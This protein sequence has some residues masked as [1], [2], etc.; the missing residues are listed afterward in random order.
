MK[1]VRRIKNSLWE[2]RQRMGFSQERASR[3]LGFKKT[4]VLSRYENGM[5]IPGLVN[6]LKLEIIYRI[7]VA[8]LYRDLYRQ[9]KEEIRER[10]EDIRES[11]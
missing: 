2:A 9:L 8:F 10:E 6:A 11:D 4:D 7:P 3:A 5:R 1:I